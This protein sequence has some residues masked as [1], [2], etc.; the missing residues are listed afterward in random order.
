MIIGQGKM[1]ACDIWNSDKGRDIIWNYPIFEIVS[2][3]FKQK[4]GQNNEK[5]VEVLCKI[6][7]WKS[8]EG[9][10]LTYWYNVTY[11]DTGVA[12]TS[13]AGDWKTQK[14]VDPQYQSPDTV[15]IPFEPGDAIEAR[16]DFR[17]RLPNV[18]KILG[19]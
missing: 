18:K 8:K 15:W 17:I 10:S 5:V 9:A 4:P 19:F 14:G 1:F 2:S 3:D 11:D 6:N 12:S 7:Y 16:Y 13:A